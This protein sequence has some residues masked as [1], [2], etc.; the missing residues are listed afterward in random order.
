MAPADLD[1]SH[2]DHSKPASSHGHGHDTPPPEGAE[3]ATDP[4][5]GMKVAITPDR[6][7]CSSG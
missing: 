1:H 5:C 7:R 6:S 4:V 3:T 2:Q